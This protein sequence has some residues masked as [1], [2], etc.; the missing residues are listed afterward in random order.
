MSIFF[1]L[2]PLEREVELQIATPFSL[3]NKR[4][5]CTP[6]PVGTPE[7][8]SSATLVPS[9]SDSEGGAATTIS[10]SYIGDGESFIA[11]KRTKCFSSSTAFVVYVQFFRVE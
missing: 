9:G 5:G 2:K 8:V 3:V 6:S 1:F 7:T 11:Y 10:A 4:I